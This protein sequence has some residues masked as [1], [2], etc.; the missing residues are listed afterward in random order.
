MGSSDV[1]SLM[2]PIVKLGENAGYEVVKNYDLGAGPID[3]AWIFKPGPPG[4]SSLPDIRIGFVNLEEHS[5]YDIN[6]AVAR[7]MFNLI[8]KLIIVVHSE[9]T[10]A[11]VSR[12]VHRDLKSGSEL[13]QLRKYVT[14]LTPSTLI[15]KGDFVSTRKPSSKYEDPEEAT[16][17]EEVV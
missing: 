11:K 1:A 17:S 15:E 16:L 10:A 7:S 2:A 14:V 9:E 13:L 8:D 5:E 6:L 12:S 4:I 3:I